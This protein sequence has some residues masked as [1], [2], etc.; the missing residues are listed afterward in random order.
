MQF[1][2]E[3]FTRKALILS[4]WHENES[5]LFHINSQ[6]IYEIFIVHQKQRMFN[7][8]QPII[9]NQMNITYYI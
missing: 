4:V 5:K 6:C 1:S 2:F 8:Q 9:Y 7:W 3:I